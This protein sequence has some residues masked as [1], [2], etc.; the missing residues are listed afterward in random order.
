MALSSIVSANS[1]FSL[2]FSSSSS[3]QPPGVGHV[4]PAELRLPLEKRRAADPVLAAQ[5]GRL[6]AGLMLL[7][8]P[9]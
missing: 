6:R 1:F 5:I 9:R 3:L 8:I 7:Q 2:P 4:H